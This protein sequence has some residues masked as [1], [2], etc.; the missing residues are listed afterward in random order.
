MPRIPSKGLAAASAV[1]LLLALGAC[2]RPAD[3]AGSV[4]RSDIGAARTTPSARAGQQ[5]APVAN[6]KA[7]PAMD[8]AAQSTKSMGA[9]AADKTR[10]LGSTAAGKVDD[11][12]ITAKVNAALAA[13]KELSAIRIDADTQ[14]GVVTLSGPAPTATAKEHAGEVA[15]GIKGVTSVNNQLTLKTG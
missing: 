1:A 2:G 3:E 13:D 6:A 15:R 10:E 9:A 14:N 7:D 5:A 11:A 4:A 12:S 8:R